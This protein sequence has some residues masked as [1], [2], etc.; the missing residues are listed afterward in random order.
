[1]KSWDTV[2]N[3][4]GS[5][6]LRRQRRGRQIGCVGRYWPKLWKYPLPGW[7]LSADTG[8]AGKGFG[9]KAWKRPAGR[10]L[11]RNGKERNEP[12]RERYRPR[13]FPTWPSFPLRF[14][15]GYFWT[16]R[17]LSILKPSRLPA[18]ILRRPCRR[19]AWSHEEKGARAL[20]CC[21]GKRRKKIP[22][23]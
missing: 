15:W 14:A 18:R 13:S 10:S 19:I 12:K 4:F 2:M 20:F 3:C 5:V 17:Q 11:A 7:R 16:L 22:C 6:S 8:H 9:W 21:W 23:G 1:M